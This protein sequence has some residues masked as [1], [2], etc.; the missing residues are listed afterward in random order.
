MPIYV[1]GKV[2][3]AKQF[4]WNESVWNPSMI[5]TALWLDAADTSTITQSGGAV[6]QWNDKSIY[7][8]NA[9]ETTSRPAYTSNGLNSKS[10]VTFDG[11][12]NKLVISS[13]FMD[14]YELLIAC[15]AKE[16]NGGFGGIITSKA[17]G[18]DR[19]PALNINNARK[20]IYQASQTVSLTSTSTGESWNIIVGQSL[21]SVSHLLAI[22]GTTQLTSTATSVISDVSSTTELG[23][24]RT[25]ADT[26]YGAFDLAELVV[27]TTNLTTINKQKIE[28]YLAWKWGL[29]ASLPNDH[30]YKLVGP[31]P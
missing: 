1:P 27:L 19:S 7:K 24:Y 16:N 8:R 12:A 21:S 15:V 29:T 30:P 31:T 26:N 18:F 20:Y 22:N 10:V 14:S 17:D 5:S 11:I 28:G 6:S 2:V 25:G 3:L 23:R 4:T 13:K 9:T